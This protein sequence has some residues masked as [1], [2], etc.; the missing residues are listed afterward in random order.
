MINTPRPRRR[1]SLPPNAWIQRF[2]G[3]PCQG[4]TFRLAT[5]GDATARLRR[6][7]EEVLPQVAGQPRSC[8]PGHAAA[9]RYAGEGGEFWDG[10]LWPAS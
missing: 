9:G 6:L 5:M 10:K 4:F 7:T 3:T 1:E 8:L 2:S